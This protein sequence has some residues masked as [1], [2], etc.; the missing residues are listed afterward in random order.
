MQ[1]LLTP[2]S[3]QETYLDWI[4][5]DP[6]IYARKL[7]QLLKSDDI[8]QIAHDVTRAYEAIR[9][10]EILEL[11][12]FNYYPQLIQPLEGEQYLYP[13]QMCTM[14]W[15]WCLPPGRRPNYHRFVLPMACH[16]R[17]KLDLALAQRLMPEHDWI[18]V[19]AERHTM[20][21]CPEAQLIFDMSYFA[22]EVSAQS[23]LHTVF[24]EKLDGSDYEVFQPE[25]F[26]WT[27]H[28]RYILHIWN[29][30]DGYPEDRRLSIIQGMGDQL[31]EMRDEDT[32]PAIEQEL[33]AA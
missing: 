23:A 11:K 3:L 2:N 12:G 4:I 6:L 30:I 33:V 19:S 13:D 29:L 14:C 10:W 18:V 17:V 15:D 32:T 7:N 25:E 1:E 22:M 20:V 31:D 8:R 5:I 26:D 28:T 21:C 27:D 9:R 16:W 24:G